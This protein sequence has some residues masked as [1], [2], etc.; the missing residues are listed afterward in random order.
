MGPELLHGIVWC[1]GSSLLATV[2]FLFVGLIPGTSETATIAP[3]TLLVILLGFPPHAV[4][5]FCLAAIATKHLVH[6]ISTAIIGVPGDNMA[7]PMLEPSAKLRALGLPHIA[8]QKMISGG[9]VAL[10]M[11]VPISVALATLLAPFGELIQRM[12]GPIFVIVGVMLS[13]SSP[14]RWASVALFLPYGVAMQGLNR[15]ALSGSGHGLTI[16]FMLGMA[17]GPMFI[18]VLTALSPVSR[19]RLKIDKPREIWLA[20][21]VKL[22]SGSIPKP[23]SVLTA[24]QLVYVFMTSVASAIA[25]S[26]TAIGMTFLVGGVVESRVKGYYNKLTTALSTMNATTESTYI[27]EVLVPLIAF[28]IPLSPISLTVALPLFNAPPVYTTEPVNNLHNLLSPLEAGA[29]GLLAV[30]VASLIAYP[31]VMRYARPASEWVMNKVAQEAVLAMFA[32]LVVVISFYEG[33]PIGIAVTAT[34]GILG[35]TLAKAVGFNIAAQMMSYFAA[36]WMMQA[37]FGI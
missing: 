15:M 21:E 22:W 20:P 31:I 17:L 23:W 35:G 37:L 25:F 27:A 30:T 4:L 9:V 33:G 8:L 24:R 2:I 28:G 12:V 14:G 5:S 7:I 36:A 10:L 19:D 29:Y 16:S 1:L 34:V 6:A 11:I 18:D 26:F 13:Y 3:A 32:G